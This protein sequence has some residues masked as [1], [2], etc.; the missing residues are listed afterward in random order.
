[1]S[2][3]KPIATADPSTAGTAPATWTDL[4]RRQLAATARAWCAVFRGFESIRRLQQATAHQALAH[5]EALAQ[6]LKGPCQPLDLVAVQAEMAR[7]DL[8]G[9]AA[10]WQQIALAMLEMQRDLAGSTAPAAQGE[11]RQLPGGA[12]GPAAPSP[13]AFKVDTGQ[14]ASTA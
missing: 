14:R 10:Y 1:M 9:A 2:V 6:A 8:Q 7:F 11:A 12:Q 3:R 13:F 4:P 5:H